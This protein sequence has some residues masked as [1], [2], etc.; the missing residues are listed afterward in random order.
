MPLSEADMGA[1][2]AVKKEPRRNLQ[3]TF[4]NKSCRYPKSLQCPVAG[5]AA[6][7]SRPGP[8]REPKLQASVQPARAASAVIAFS[9]LT[10]FWRSKRK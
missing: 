3:K 8:E 10:F 1:L 9:L 5:L 6:G 4:A 2:S 7:Y